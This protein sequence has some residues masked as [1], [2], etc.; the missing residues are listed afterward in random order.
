M[1]TSLAYVYALS[2]KRYEAR[3]RLNNIIEYAKKNFVSPFDIAYVYGALGEKEEA[4][5][6][7]EKGYSEN[8]VQLIYL[9]ADPAF[10]A[11]S[12]DPRFKALLKK[13]GLDK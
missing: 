8:D 5:S 10:D 6:W 3:K 4:L 1:S 7:L 11:L 2:G 13:V 12:S 9:K